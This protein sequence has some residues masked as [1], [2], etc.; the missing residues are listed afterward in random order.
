MADID[1]FNIEPHQISRD[2]SGYM[3][4]IYAPG[5][6]GKTTL[7]ASMPKP[8]LLACEKGYNALAGVKPV[9]VTSWGDIRKVMKQ[10]SDPR[11]HEIYQTVVID[12]V[13]KASQLCEKYMCNKLSIENIGDGG[14]STNGWAKVKKEWEATFN[15]LAMMGYAI[16][17]ISHDKD[18]TFTRK[19]G[20]TY[21]QIIPS[22]SNAYNEIIRNMVDLQAYG[23]IEDGNRYLVF[24]SPDDSIQCKSRFSHMQERVPLGYQELVDALNDAIDK[25]DGTYVTDKKVAT[26]VVQELDFD[27][28]MKSFQELV[29]KIQAGAGNDFG[30]TWAPKIAATVE[31]YLGKGKKVSDM[32][33][34][35]AE[36]LDLIIYDLTEQV[37]QGL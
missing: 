10:L 16:V 6:F 5:G 30:S 2:L 33:P 1:I 19:D 12:T 27:D 7:A 35:Q 9:D 17:F 3:T 23:L 26:P 28:L 20:T 14:W 11:A 32:T 25:E 8:L 13:D 4:Y 15:S 29:G 31:K 22:C 24:R 37:G 36:Q 34:S 21:N 18:K